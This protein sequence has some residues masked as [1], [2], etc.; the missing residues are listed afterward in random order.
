MLKKICSFLLYFVDTEHYENKSG[1][2]EKLCMTLHPTY[3]IMSKNYLC[4]HAHVY[5]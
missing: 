3:A 1:N 5:A 2:S 4:A